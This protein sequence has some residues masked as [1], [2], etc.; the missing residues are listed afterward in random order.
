MLDAISREKQIKARSRAAKAGK[1]KRSIPNGAIFTAI[2][3]DA[4]RLMHPFR[5]RGALDCLDSASQ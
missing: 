1:F 3:L 5:Q 2:L 4:A